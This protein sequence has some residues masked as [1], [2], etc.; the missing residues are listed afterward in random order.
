MK[1]TP[2]PRI[3]GWF[4]PALTVFIS[5]FAWP[6]CATDDVQAI[7]DK[8]DAYRSNPE[9]FPTPAPTPP[10]R[11]T[12]A[13][14]QTA[15]PKEKVSQ[16]VPPK[17]RVPRIDPN[18]K[19]FGAKDKLPR[20]IAGQPLAGE[21]FVLGEYINGGTVLYAVEDDGKG[22]LR[23]YV[24]VNRTSGLAPGNYFDQGR[25]PRVTFSREQPLVFVKKLFP[26]LYAVQVP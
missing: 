21:F 5:V 22:F 25:R 8:V 3:R 1:K 2:R 23:Q 12:A 15:E 9:Q 26:G 17:E 20:K 11:N 7:L 10:P 19:V 18:I 24:V 6:I 14:A 4:I 16:A 13:P